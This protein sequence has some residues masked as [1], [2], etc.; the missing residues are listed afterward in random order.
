[1]QNNRK[2]LQKICGKKNYSALFEYKEN[3]TPLAQLEEHLTFNQRVMGS[4]PMW[5]ISSLKTK[6]YNSEPPFLKR[7]RSG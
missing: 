7:V 6:D 5:G 2:I 1:M 4:N 3:F